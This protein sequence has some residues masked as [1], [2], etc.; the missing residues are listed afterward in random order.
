MAAPSRA[1]RVLAPALA[2]AGLLLLW[3]AAVD[4][5]IVPNFL[6]PTPVQVVMALVEDA[7]LI[8]GH[9]AVT[10]AEAAAGLALGVALGFAFAVL[11]DRFETFYL[12]FEPLMTVS[13]T[14]PT[15]AIAPLLVLWLGYGALPK[16]V[17]VVVSTFF[18]ITVSLVSGFRSVDPDA[19]DLMRTMNASRWQIFWYAKLPAAAEQFF[20]GLRISATYAIVGAV[21]A[22]WLGGNVGLG[23]YMTRVRKS[24]SY[25]R[26]FASII[27]ITALSLGLM[28]LVELAQR[29]CM[30]WKRAEGK[31]HDR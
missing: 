12:A 13:Q 29:A 4:L 25:D 19:I 17:L 9:C 23:V 11:M 15:V 3:E 18:P 10:L 31:H 5:G 24:F 2:I 20:S 1:R 28:K 6:L 30:P 26:L 14:I 16:I 22:E 27:V 7:P 21:I 8:A